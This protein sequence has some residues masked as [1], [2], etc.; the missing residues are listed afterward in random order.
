MVHEGLHNVLKELMPLINVIAPS[1]LAYLATKSSN[2]NKQQFSE[3]K[4]DLDKVSKTVSNNSSTLDRVQLDIA[5]VRHG[6]MRTQR[7]MLYHALDVSIERGYTTVEERREMAML[8]E[9]YT[10]LGG[11]GEI[12]ALYKVFEK[13]ETRT[14]Q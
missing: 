8:Y 9:S 13:L 7:H 11:N 6:E 2:L 3:L 12:K 10:K 5:D 4:N 14:N 1:Y